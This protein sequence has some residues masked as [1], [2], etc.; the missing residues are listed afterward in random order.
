M[1]VLPEEQKRVSPLA[2]DHEAKLISLAAR[3]LR[4]LVGTL[5][6]APSLVGNAS[7]F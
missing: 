4:Q 6:L 3:C 1:L 2:N 5:G 7:P